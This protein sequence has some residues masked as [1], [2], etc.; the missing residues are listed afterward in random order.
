MI[1]KILIAILSLQSLTA[2]SEEATRIYF[3]RNGESEFSSKDAEGIKHT[4]GK[5][6]HVPLTEEGIEQAKQFGEWLSSEGLSGI[7]YTP[8]ALRAEQT[9]ALLKLTPGGTYE[10]LFEV[11]MGDWEGKLK[12]KA[13]KQEYQKWK[14]LS[15][16]EKYITPKVVGGES[17][18]EAS[19]RAFIDLQALLDQNEGETFFVVTGENLLRALFIRWTHPELSKEPGSDLPAPSMGP[20]DFY[21][22][23]IPR[24]QPIESGR[25]LDIK[26]T[27]GT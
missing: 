13:Y 20:C 2:S 26:F 17:F 27:K 4:S 8:P 6:P 11:G 22:I 14:V 23:E 21:I 12:D 25:H 1:L 19:E 24:G 15:A 16:Q 7:V 10:G 5:S 3:V 9:A 18:Y